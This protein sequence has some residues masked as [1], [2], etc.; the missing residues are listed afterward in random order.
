VYQSASHYIPTKKVLQNR[1]NGAYVITLLWQL[2]IPYH[3]RL[4]RLLFSVTVTPVICRQGR[5]LPDGALTRLH[6]KGTPSLTLTY[7]TKVK[8]RDIHKHSS[9]LC[10]KIFFVM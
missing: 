6:S 1:T 3:S 4:E 5:T 7:W 2:S 8:V 9:L 10:S